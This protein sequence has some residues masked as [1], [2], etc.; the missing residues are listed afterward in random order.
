MI[1][2]WF[3]VKHCVCD[4]LYERMLWEK[5]HSK[6]LAVAMTAYRWIHLLKLMYSIHHKTHKQCASYLSSHSVHI[7]VLTDLIHLWFTDNTV[8]LNVMI[9]I[10][11]FTTEAMWHRQVLYSDFILMWKGHIRHSGHN[12]PSKIGAQWHVINVF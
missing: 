7:V 3:S 4:A 12:G 6:C 9:S 10:F 5:G 8:Y 11:R 1:A 2:V